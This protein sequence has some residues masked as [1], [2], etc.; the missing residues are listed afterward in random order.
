MTLT[1]MLDIVACA[2][3]VAA[4]F[5]KGPKFMN[6]LATGVAIISINHLLLPAA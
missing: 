3:L 6:S 2:F 5:G 1:F 4:A